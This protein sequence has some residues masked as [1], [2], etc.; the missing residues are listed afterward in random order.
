ME[1]D[2]MNGSYSTHGS[3]IINACNILDGTLFGNS[4][5][6]RPRRRWKDNIKI[7]CK[8]IGIQLSQDTD[9]RRVLVNTV[10]NP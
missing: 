10:M 7:D 5:L 6:G 3:Q 1:G 4:P 9:Q 2:E 8:G